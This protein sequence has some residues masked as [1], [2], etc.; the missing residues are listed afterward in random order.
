LKSVGLQYRRRSGRGNETDKR[1]GCL[2]SFADRSDAGRQH[3]D[4]LKL[5]WEW[6]DEI[7]ARRND[8]LGDLADA[9]LSKT[10][11]GR[12]PGDRSSLVFDFKASVSPSPRRLLEIRNKLCQSKLQRT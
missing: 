2:R 12:S 6:I 3:A 8:D 11:S 5:A 4:I 9:T 10:F 1:P 7:D